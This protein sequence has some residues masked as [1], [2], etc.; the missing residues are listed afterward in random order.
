M[1]Q[2]LQNSPAMFNIQ[3]ILN[4]KVKLNHYT[5]YYNFLIVFTYNS[6]SLSNKS[7]EFWAPD[8]VACYSSPHLSISAG[9]MPPTRSPS[10]LQ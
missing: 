4:L 6:A 7:S 5:F 3:V 9:S 10:Q 2:E 1:C 8:T